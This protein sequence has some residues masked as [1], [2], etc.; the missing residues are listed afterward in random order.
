M[1]IARSKVILHKN[2]NGTGHNTSKKYFVNNMMIRF[3]LLSL[4]A[5]LPAFSHAEVLSLKEST[6]AAETAGKAVFIKF[7][8]P[9]YVQIASF[10][11]CFAAYSSTKFTLFLSLSVSIRCG[12]CQALAPD[13]EKLAAEWEGHKV[14]LVAEVDCDNDDAAELC[15]HFDISGFPTL[16]YGDPNNLESYEGSRTFEDLS[17]FAKKNIA[18]PFCSV[19]NT[20]NCDEATKKL[21]KELEGKDV[22]ELKKLVLDT[23]A[24]VTEAES[25]FEVEIEKLQKAY[26][27]LESAYNE[28]VAKIKE[29][30]NYKLVRSVVAAKG[31]FAADDLDA[32][33]FDSEDE[34]GDEL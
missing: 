21:I 19:S 32:D 26:E 24:K 16:L 5:A 29:E 7:F 6:F 31:G 17:E 34:D 4:F 8:A 20:D 9:W 3:A 30:A 33:D 10:N 11:K 27:S 13:W 23:D 22:D 25:V 15:E 18:T 1:R 2:A 28:K 14:G 12:H